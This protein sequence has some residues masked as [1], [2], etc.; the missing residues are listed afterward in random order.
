MGQDYAKKRNYDF[1]PE[2]R[3]NISL[4]SPFVRSRLI[5]EEEIV[6]TALAAHSYHASEKFIQEVFWRS[7]WKGWLELRPQI[8]DEYLSQLREEKQ[9]IAD[10]PDTHARYQAACNAE[11]PHECF[12]FWVNELR[13]TGYLHNHARMWF[14]S[15]WIFF[16]ELPWQLGADFF[17]RHLLDGD[18]AS[19][20][21]SWR[22]VAG[23]H[24]KGKRYIATSQN[25]HKFTAGRF[26]PTNLVEPDLSTITTEPFSPPPPSEYP[27]TRTQISSNQQIVLLVHDEDLYPEHSPFSE[28][29]VTHIIGLSPRLL[30]ER[31]EV[32]ELVLEFRESALNDAL[33]RARTFFGVHSE[34]ISTEKE[35]LSLFEQAQEKEQTSLGLLKPKTGYWKDFFDSLKG[36]PGMD[37]KLL[38]EAERSWDSYLYPHARSGFFK[39]K[40]Q[41]PAAI[42]EMKLDQ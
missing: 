34:S 9:A 39:F 5:L 42:K 23:L 12:N 31:Q 26:H 40:N 15:I 7:Y 24:T 41:I 27:T 11:S 17:Y 13:T 33:S 22:W 14:A 38:L 21:L 19:N 16:L 30:Q 25:I 3:T 20:T 6:R 37:Q 8:W 4:L 36:K 29:Q 2:Q 10:S 35:L 1:G 32:S 18:S 28:Q